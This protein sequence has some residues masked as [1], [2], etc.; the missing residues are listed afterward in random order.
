M[1][2]KCDMGRCSG[3]LSELLVCDQPEKEIIKSVFG[4]VAL[5]AHLQF[6]VKRALQYI[7]SKT[8]CLFKPNN[9]IFYPIRDQSYGLLLTRASPP[10]GL[11]WLAVELAVGL[12]A[13]IAVDCRGTTRKAC[14]GA[15]P[16]PCRRRCHGPC[17]R[18]CRGTCGGVHRGACHGACSEPC[19]GLQWGSPRGSLR[20]LT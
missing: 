6:C 13:G 12:A 17:H 7:S 20:S 1:L 11:P 10:G 3:E 8:M 9:T 19:R 16:G 4:A 18:P 15:C 14:H 2:L 5:R